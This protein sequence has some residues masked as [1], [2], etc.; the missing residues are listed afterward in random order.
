MG[1]SLTNQLGLCPSPSLPLARRS[2]SYIG[3]RPRRPGTT[4]VF[5]PKKHGPWRED[6]GYAH[7]RVHQSRSTGIAGWVLAL[8]GFRVVARMCARPPGRN[9]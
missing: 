7:V 1:P 9:S 2:C 3:L 4:V 6:S 5:D 8:C